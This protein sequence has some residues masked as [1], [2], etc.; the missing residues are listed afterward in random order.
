MSI[1]NEIGHF[2]ENR[3]GMDPNFALNRTEKEYVRCQIEY[4]KLHRTLETIQNELSNIT[5]KLTDKNDKDSLIQLDTHI[6]ALSFQLRVE[7]ERHVKSLAL[8]GLTWEIHSLLADSKSSPPNL[9]SPIQFSFTS[10]E[11]ELSME[12][13]KLKKLLSQLHQMLDMEIASSELELLQC[14]GVADKND[15]LRDLCE[16]YIEKNALLLKFAECSESENKMHENTIRY[17]TKEVT[18]AKTASIVIP[19]ITITEYLDG[20]KSK[21]TDFVKKFVGSSG[22]V[23]SKIEDLIVLN[24]ELSCENKTLMADIADNEKT[25]EGLKCDIKDMKSVQGKVTDIYTENK[26]LLEENK[27][28]QDAVEKLEV[29]L[30]DIE[31]DSAV[32]AS[33]DMENLKLE[34]SEKQTLL[35]EINESKKYYQKLFHELK[36]LRRPKV[37]HIRGKSWSV[38]KTTDNEDPSD[39]LDPVSE[40]AFALA[41]EKKRLDIITREKK[42]LL[43]SF[44]CLR[45]FLKTLQLQEGHSYKLT[46]ENNLAEIEFH[47]PEEIKMLLKEGE[48]ELIGSQQYESEIDYRQE[49]QFEVDELNQML[50]ESYAKNYQISEEVRKL[51][52]EVKMYKAKLREMSDLNQNEP[53]QLLNVSD[54]LSEVDTSSDTMLTDQNNKCK[55]K[56]AVANLEGDFSCYTEPKYQLMKS[57]LLGMGVAQLQKGVKYAVYIQ[58][59]DEKGEI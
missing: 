43:N 47:L 12:K 42:T 22:A 48:F 29:R 49:M 10:E 45:N 55:R 9:D 51:K 21:D 7:S 28:L 58:P 33:D 46:L 14:I 25:I 5:T 26:E 57:T 16:C 30:K 44:F 37:I 8:S 23:N 38:V 27:Q 34:L 19:T 39:R 53:I 11:E 59:L 18:K 50:Q 36:A 40:L 56:V 4:E 3:P 17:L 20:E 2:L 41:E 52:L 6:D 15:K 1:V 54:S 13:R 31:I 24:E 32:T 35:A